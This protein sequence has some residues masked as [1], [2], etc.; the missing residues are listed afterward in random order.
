MS[1][2]LKKEKGVSRC[3]RHV[4]RRRLTFRTDGE[5]VTYVQKLQTQPTKG[6]KKKPIESA[7]AENQMNQTCADT[8]GSVAQMTETQTTAGTAGSIYS[9]FNSTL[10]PVMVK[11]ESQQR[12][13]EHTA[14]I[15][16]SLPEHGAIGSKDDMFDPGDRID[17]GTE[18]D[19][20]FTRNKSLEP[21]GEGFAHLV[22]D[23]PGQEPAGCNDRSMGIH[24]GYSS[25]SSVLTDQVPV[26]P[27]PTS[28]ANGPSSSYQ[29]WP[30]SMDHW[31][32]VDDAIFA[33]GQPR[34]SVGWPEKYPPVPQ[35]APSN[36]PHGLPWDQQLL[37]CVENGCPVSHT[38]GWRPA[39][40][41]QRICA[42]YGCNLDP[43]DAPLCFVD[44]RHPLPDAQFFTP[45]FDEF[46]AD[47]TKSLP[48]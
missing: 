8:S 9:S 31:S 33:A 22:S 48:S 26:R 17:P 5:D 15:Q 2:P 18:L 36:H 4:S 32:F 20:I 37:V 35:T 3:T 41:Q 38:H 42:A 24:I 44:P 47:V 23:Q 30:A 46:A 45:S 7:G 16:A 25:A 10:S 34:S 1:K 12:N 13:A 43:R 28:V 11:C 14:T 21:D 27:R 19:E 29:Y 40:E 39:K 6:R